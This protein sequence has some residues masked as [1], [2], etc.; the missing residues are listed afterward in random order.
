[1][2]Q[3]L[4]VLRSLFFFWRVNLAVCLGVVAATAVLTGALLVG[5]SM[6]GSLRK[7]SLDGLGEVDEILLTDR[8]FREQLADE[9]KSDKSFQADF[10]IAE[11]VILFP[12]ASA[13]YK[14][15]E[16]D[17]SLANN[18]ALIGCRNSW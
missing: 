10:D 12:N 4:Y 18:V 17:S 5:D 16:S 14:K 1:M 7:I 6:R 11:P 2:S 15:T 13:S 8:F 9:I 3:Y